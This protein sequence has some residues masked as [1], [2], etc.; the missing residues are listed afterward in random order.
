MVAAMLRTCGLREPKEAT[1][2]APPELIAIAIAKP[3]SN[4]T[5]L[6]STVSGY[7]HSYLVAGEWEENWTYKAC[8]RTANVTVKFSADGLGG[9]HLSSEQKGKD[10]PGI[11]QQ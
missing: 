2:D 4:A 10:I 8:D 11:P 1:K 9:A 6:P 3:L 7:E 5:Y